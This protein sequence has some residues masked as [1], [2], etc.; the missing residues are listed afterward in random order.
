MNTLI[1]RIAAFVVCTAVASQASA[2]VLMAGSL[3]GDPDGSVVRPMMFGDQ[4]VA[5]VK[6]CFNSIPNRPIFVAGSLISHSRAGAWLISQGVRRD[7]R[8]QPQKAD[9]G[10]PA[11]HGQRITP[12]PPSESSRQPVSTFAQFV[13]KLKNHSERGGVEAIVSNRDGVV[14][15]TS[16]MTLIGLIAVALAGITAFIS[17]TRVGLVRFMSYQRQ[18]QLV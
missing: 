8:N 5:P 6:H 15:R 18:T 16:S 10:L 12:V 13:Q 7:G 4:G 9:V 11:G 3:G 2:D 17:V 14:P 1:S